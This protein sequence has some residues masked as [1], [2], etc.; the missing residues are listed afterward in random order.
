MKVVY[1]GSFDPPTAGHFDIIKRI[2]SLF[3]DVTVLVADNKDKTAE[4]SAEARA[5]LIREAMPSVKVELFGGLLA[6]YCSSR[7]VEAIVKGIRGFADYD[8]EYI[9]S[10]INKKLCGVETIFIPA[11]AEYMHLSSTAVKAVEKAGGD[12]NKLL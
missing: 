12:V 6:D 11:S 10:I 4:L 2:S 7:S 3:D 9:Q 1:P 8:Y 5:E